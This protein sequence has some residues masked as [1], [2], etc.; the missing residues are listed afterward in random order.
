MSNAKINW[1]KI[2]VSRNNASKGLEPSVT[3]LN[4]NNLSWLNYDD[5]L[6]SAESMQIMG[7]P[8]E[9][10]NYRDLMMKV[11]AIFQ[12]TTTEGALPSRIDWRDI[13]NNEFTEDAVQNVFINLVSPLK[14]VTNKEKG[15]AQLNLLYAKYRNISDSDL[16]GIFINEMRGSKL[17]INRNSKKANST[18][19]P[20]LLR[21]T[22]ICLL[23]IH[24][25]DA[26][27]EWSVWNYVP[28]VDFSS[29]EAFVNSSG[30]AVVNIAVPQVIQN[31]V[32]A[33]E[34]MY[35]GL[36]L[37]ADS[38]KPNIADVLSYA[39]A[40]IGHTC[41]SAS[42]A[43]AGATAVAAVGPGTQPAVPFLAVGALGAGIC[44]L[45]TGISTLALNAANVAL[46]TTGHVSGIKPLEGGWW[47]Y[48]GQ[49]SAD[50]ATKV[51][52][53]YAME[54]ISTGV[55]E[56]LLETVE[57]TTGA[58]GSRTESTPGSLTT[59]AKGNACPKALGRTNS[60]RNSG[61]VG[62]GTQQAPKISSSGVRFKE[63]A[64][65]NSGTPSQ[66]KLIDGHESE[67]WSSSKTKYVPTKSTTLGYTSNPR[68]QEV[69]AHVTH[70]PPTDTQIMASHH[71][72][73]YL[74][75]LHKKDYN[76]RNQGTAKVLSAVKSKAN[77]TS[78]LLF[79]EQ[80]TSSV[81]AA[82]KG[83]KRGTRAHLTTTIL[84]A[85]GQY[86]GLPPVH[87]V[88]KEADE[89]KTTAPTPYSLKGL[90]TGAAAIAATSA[91][92]GIGS[93]TMN[94]P[95]ASSTLLAGRGR[96]T[97]NRKSRKSTKQKKTRS[98]KRRA[99]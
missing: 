70:N 64:K 45:G 67:R 52:I 49:K 38:D 54:R 90:L 22:L 46:R 2:L 78:E 94:L 26:W 97:T 19:S 55:Q 48:M 80:P 77:P 16:K 21:I 30:K 15:L 68:A 72:A 65:S 61:T 76:L 10:E 34:Y 36:T 96:R 81:L 47:W 17:P 27:Q 99:F 44:R 51:A 95:P 35:S 85:N 43:L 63:L 89:N 50:S 79:T 56:T 66:I 58:P 53:G 60:G 93:R 39:S 57:T 59:E 23:A 25:V 88:P 74:R 5:C 41:A 28:Y 1:D 82:A 86:Y 6:S 75:Q 69:A 98:L 91:G 40:Q 20:T 9:R 83:E 24:S 12:C 29:P 32:K 37:F 4:G 7:T 84:G 13:A 33:G 73:T 31:P 71:E 92:T 11:F 42:T 3:P 62:T 18:L 8:A 87:P 14:Q